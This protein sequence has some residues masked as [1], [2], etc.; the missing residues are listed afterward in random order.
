M[1]KVDDLTFRIQQ[2]QLLEQTSFQWNGPAFH[3]I[4]GPNGAGKS[5]LLKLCSGLITPTTGEIYLE[6]KPLSQIS[7]TQ[8]ARQ[9]AMLTQQQDSPFQFS[10]RDI[11]LMGRIPHFQRRPQSADHRVVDAMLAHFG[12]TE[13]Q[14]RTV[15]TLSGGERQRVHLARVVAQLIAPEQAQPF[16]RKIL[17]LDEPST[18]LDVAQQHRFMQQIQEL[19][20]QGLTVVAVL[21]EL[22]LA[23]RYA[24]QLHLMSRGKMVAS[25]TPE[26]L[27]QPDLLSHAYQMPLTVCRD[28]SGCPHVLPATLAH[29][30]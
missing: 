16:D 20:Q 21:H 11:V 5:T 28:A 13:W 25:G 22:D 7:S 19:I 18:W 9:R 15:Q 8:L 30:A 4:I 6:N 1:L 3:A 23:A 27:L 2:N 14:H 24:D 10:V 17:F 26:H 29:S 12:L